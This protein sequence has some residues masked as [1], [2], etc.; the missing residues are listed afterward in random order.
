MVG[1]ATVSTA[2]IMLGCILYS[3]VKHETGCRI[4]RSY[5]VLSGLEGE[6]RLAKFPFLYLWGGWMGDIISNPICYFNPYNMRI[7]P[8]RKQGFL[9]HT[10]HMREI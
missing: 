2:P 10:P 4:Y 5:I 3:R 9:E 7:S 1:R 6:P 8:L